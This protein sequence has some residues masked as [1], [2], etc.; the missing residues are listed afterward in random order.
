MD[1]TVLHLIGAMSF[2]RKTFGRLRSN[3]PFPFQYTVGQMQCRPNDFRTNG[4]RPKVVELKKNER[5]ETDG[6]NCFA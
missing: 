6:I 5:E 4:S 1:A 3:R 2:G